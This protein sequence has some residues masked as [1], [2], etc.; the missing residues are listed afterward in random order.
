M[1]SSELPA[2][3]APTSSRVSIS[4]RLSKTGR[5]VIRPLAR[6]T[7]DVR[8]VAPSIVLKTTITEPFPVFY[9]HADKLTERRRETAQGPFYN[10]PFVQYHEASDENWVQWRADQLRSQGWTVTVERVS[11]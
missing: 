10:A 11:R 3:P 8:E 5:I 4:G 2:A 6:R 1:P 9:G 7:R